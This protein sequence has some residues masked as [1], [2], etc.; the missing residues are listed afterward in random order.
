MFSIQVSKLI[1]SFCV[2]ISKRLREIGFGINRMM[3]TLYC[4]YSP[5]EQNSKINFV[6]GFG[7]RNLSIPLILMQNRS[8]ET[9]TWLPVLVPKITCRKSAMHMLKRRKRKQHDI[10]GRTIHWEATKDNSPLARSTFVPPPPR[11]NFADLT[12]L[13]VHYLRN[14]L[15]SVCTLAGGAFSRNKDLK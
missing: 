7:G 8:H 2:C 1:D 3:F 13:K 9:T 10:M 4:I 14:I 15:S 12:S 11:G 6:C 5:F